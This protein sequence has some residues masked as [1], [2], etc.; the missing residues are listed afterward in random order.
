MR[1]PRQDRGGIGDYTAGRCNAATLKSTFAREPAAD[2]GRAILDA[3]VA[4]MEADAAR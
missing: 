1:S 3:V 4:R 2:R